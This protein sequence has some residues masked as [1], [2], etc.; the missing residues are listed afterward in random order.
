M[1]HVNY[2]ILTTNILQ[3]QPLL[4]FSVADSHL[5]LRTN[6]HWPP[7]TPFLG[8]FQL[9]APPTGLTDTCATKRQMIQLVNE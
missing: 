4:P 7:R 1:S 2:C 9:T 5:E 8:R 6:R 3:I